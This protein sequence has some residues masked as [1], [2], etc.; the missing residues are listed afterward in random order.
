[1][2][3]NI[4]TRVKEAGRWRD[5]RNPWPRRHARTTRA[6]CA[7]A[8][9][10]KEAPERQYPDNC[11]RT[12]QAACGRA[13]HGRS[14][15]PSGSVLSLRIAKSNI[16]RQLRF[17][18]VQFRVGPLRGLPFALTVFHLRSKITLHMSSLHRRRT[19]AYKEILPHESGTSEGTAYQSVAEST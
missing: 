6:L 17:A 15:S 18:T 3:W 10:E 1:R 16:A 19:V 4:G 5:R 14:P 7:R 12:P 13:D 2:W 8:G 9:D 11:Q